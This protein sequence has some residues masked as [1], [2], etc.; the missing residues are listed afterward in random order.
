MS[1]RQLEHRH[2]CARI[3]SSRLPSPRQPVGDLDWPDKRSR[4]DPG[5]GGSLPSSLALR[6]TREG[7]GSPGC[8]GG[9]PGA[10]G[11]RQEAVCPCACA[12]RLSPCPSAP[13]ERASRP[14]CLCRR[15]CTARGPDRPRGPGTEWTAH[16]CGHRLGLPKGRGPGAR[17]ARPA[18]KLILRTREDPPPMKHS[19]VRGLMLGSN[20]KVSPGAKRLFRSSR[21]VAKLESVKHGRGAGSRETE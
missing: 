10:C 20:P 6:V 5:Q 11:L 16:G 17:W 14:R 18:P 3:L 9:A 8:R 21:I 15:N 13:G 12:Q 2:T 4:L 7:T 19:H 1:P